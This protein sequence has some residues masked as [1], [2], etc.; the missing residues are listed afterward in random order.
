MVSILAEE[1]FVATDDTPR[2]RDGTKCRAYRPGLQ[3]RS[4]RP[5]RLRERR[6][7]NSP[8]R[9]ARLTASK[10]TTHRW[11]WSGRAGAAA[12]DAALAVAAGQARQAAEGTA[13][14]LQRPDD[15]PL[16]R[17]RHAQGAAA[18]EVGEAPV[19]DRL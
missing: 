11:R 4:G 6:T 16:R 3:S 8:G 10:R 1:A 9:D 18:G 5:P 2:G 13:R 15:H 19:D 14:Q 12:G 17:T 7:P